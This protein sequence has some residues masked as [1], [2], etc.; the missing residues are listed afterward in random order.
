MMMECTLRP[1][2]PG[3]FEAI[4]SIYRH[5]VET[6]CASFELEP[7][8]AGEMRRRWRNV[9]ELGLPY[10]VAE[11][12][13]LVAGYSYAT[14]YRPR[15]AY[16]FTVEDSVYVRA[17]LSG[18]GL[19]SRLL[20]GLIAECEAGQWRQ[21]VAVIGDSANSASIRLHSRFGFRHV[22]TLQNV[23]FKFGRW[24]DTVL[25]QR[26][27]RSATQEVQPPGGSPGSLVW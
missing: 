23:G 2:V 17:D 3:D 12:D 27:L 10:L 24:V 15:P 13:G 7:P 14:L 4:A 8:D 19:G 18:R 25:M 22:G 26:A 21:M 16:R 11:V 20:G 5:H 1:A 9:V 6:G